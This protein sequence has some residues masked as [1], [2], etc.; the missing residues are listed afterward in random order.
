MTVKKGAPVL[1]WL[2]WALTG[3]AGDL[4]PPRSIYGAIQNGVVGP[5]T[6]ILQVSSSGD[7]AAGNSTA[8]LNLHNSTHWTTNESQPWIFVG[9]GVNPVRVVGFS[10]QGDLSTNWPTTFKIDYLE[11]PGTTWTAY[12][13]GASITGPYEATT[14][15]RRTILQPFEAFAVRFT[16]LTSQL[17][18]HSA[19]LEVQYETFCRP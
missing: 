4:C 1:A 3:V 17:T 8:G 15:L 18:L 11:T 6:V 2:V 14:E 16:L 19:K 12:L 9:F 10:I 7:S 5:R 13:G